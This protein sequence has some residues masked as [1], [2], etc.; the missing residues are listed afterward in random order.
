MMPDLRDYSS[1]SGIFFGLS[2]S[3]I[4]I[5]DEVMPPNR[6]STSNIM[7]ND[8]GSPCVKV[9]KHTR[10]NTQEK[11]ADLIATGNWFLSVRRL[12]R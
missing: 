12:T 10:V 8:D 2:L 1:C 3:F 9:I 11:T 7:K 4:V 6:K 5:I